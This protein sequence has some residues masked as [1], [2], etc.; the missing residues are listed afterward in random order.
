MMMRK[1]LVKIESLNLDDYR[2]YLEIMVD[3]ILAMEDWQVIIVY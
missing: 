1:S 3:L 2:A